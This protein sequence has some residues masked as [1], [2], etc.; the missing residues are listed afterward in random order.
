MLTAYPPTVGLFAV[1]LSDGVLTPAWLIGGFAV[2]AVLV[3]VSLWRIGEGQIARVGL[4]T[5]AFFVASQVHI[6]VGVGSVHLMLNGVVGVVLRRFA[7]LAIAEGLLLQALLFGHGGPT[8]LG[9]NVCVLSIPAL[10]AG[11]GYPVLRRA[12][13]AGR[14]GVVLGAA[15]VA[16]WA[17]V[18][19]AAGAVE[20]V[21]RTAG[22]ERQFDLAG[23]AGWWALAPG[24]VAAAAAVAAAGVWLVRRMD[25]GTTFVCGVTVGLAACL[26]TVLLNAA[27]LAFGGEEDWRALVGLVLVAHL[28]VVAVEAL[29]TGVVVGYLERVKPEWLAAP[30]G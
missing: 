19:V 22:G 11:Y 16:G 14:P 27:A 13:R 5:A 18:V 4:L 29:G 8:A 7:P 30:P 20:A 9:V 3:A 17:W 25:T 21:V 15:W 26:L 6:S 10:L 28:P 24:A 12:A 2:A 23:L 1:H